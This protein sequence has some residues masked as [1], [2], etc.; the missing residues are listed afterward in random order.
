MPKSYLLLR[1]LTSLS[2]S[3][4]SSPTPNDS[5]LRYFNRTLAFTSRYFEIPFIF[6]SSSHPYSLSSINAANS[7]SSSAVIT[8]SFFSSST[9]SSTFPSLSSSASL[10]AF[11][12]S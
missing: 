11:A 8:P 4:Q 3:S 1:I 12:K 5:T 6:F 10:I 9:T 2:T 7:S